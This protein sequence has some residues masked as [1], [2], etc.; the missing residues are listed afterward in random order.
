[1][2]FQYL[3]AGLVCAGCLAFGGLSLSY[4]RVYAPQIGS[5]EEMMPA[6]SKRRAAATPKPV[7]LERRVEDLEKQVQSL[8]LELNALRKELKPLATQP[9]RPRPL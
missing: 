1:M 4:E 7:A 8:K 2:R 6:R 9:A 5:E 3:I